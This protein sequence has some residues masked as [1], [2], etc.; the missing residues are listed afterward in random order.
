[1]LIEFDGGLELRVREPNKGTVVRAIRKE[2]PIDC[3]VSYLGDDLTDEDAFRALKG[4][5]L[6]LLVRPEY[7]S[8]TADAW[9][10]PPEELATFLNDWLRIC[11]GAA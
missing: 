8:T 1:M 11:G 3:P 9:L 6:S 4:E 7:R 5:G 10:R 2:L